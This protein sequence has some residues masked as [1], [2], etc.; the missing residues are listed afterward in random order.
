[1]IKA[2]ELREFRPVVRYRDGNQITLQ[3]VQEAIKDCAQ[4]MGI[5]VAFYTDQVKSG[6]MFNKTIEDCIVLYHPEHQYDYFKICVRVSHQGCYA[7]VSAMD[8]GTSKQMKKAG[9]AE[10]YRADRKGKSMSYKV[11][12]MIGQ[13]LTSIGRSK[14]K[15]EEEQNYYACIIDIFDEI[16]S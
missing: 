11:G 13:G 2:D 7:F 3:T 10:A 14:S 9:Q 8:F 4:G 12:S 1:M 5:P 6:G 15:L 16:V